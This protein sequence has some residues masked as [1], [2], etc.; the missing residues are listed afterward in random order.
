MSRIA[1]RKKRLGLLVLAVLVLGL[2]AVVGVNG[3]TQRARAQVDV[4]T[5]ICTTGTRT[6]NQVTFDLEV[7][8]GYT[9]TPDGNSLYFWG[10]S[11]FGEAFQSPGVTLCINEGDEV[12]VNLAN[13][14]LAE[15]VSIIFPGQSGVTATGGVAGL[16]TNEA[17]PGGSV[18]YSFTAG[19]PG[20]YLYESGT[21]AYRQVQMGLY[22]GLIVYPALNSPGHTYAYNDVATEYN[23]DREFLLIMHDIDPDLHQ[24]VE[25]GDTY[26]VTTMHDRYWTINGRSF[27]DVLFGHFVPWL[28]GQ[29]Y[30]GMVQ[31]EPYDATTNPLPALVRYANAG[32]INHPFHPHGN[33]LEIIARD[34]RLLR[35]LNG[36]DTGYESFTTTV[37][38]GQTYDLLAMWTDVEAWDP[39]ANQVPVNPQFPMPGLYNLVDAEDGFFGGSPYLGNQADRLVGT[40]P[41]NEC[42]EFYF[43]WHSHAL[44]EF[45]NFDEGFGGLATLWR[46][47]PPGGCP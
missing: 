24:A 13:N 33:N 19:E 1:S 26:D 27:P 44:N 25:R 10:Y 41:Y 15:N 31:I 18:S 17:A 9:L 38:S 43:P 29:P 28:P 8:E 32:M 39:I 35:G 42:G 34:G 30:G 11:V 6:G 7:K 37:G 23:P 12:T 20:T 45:Q 3:R 16:F 22:G 46:V 47:D 4:T 40:V 14:E 21:E 2:I 5:V 36:E